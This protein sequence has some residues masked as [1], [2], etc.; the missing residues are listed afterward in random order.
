M[1]HL[2]SRRSDHQF[3][4][5]SLFGIVLGRDYF[6]VSRTQLSELIELIFYGVVNIRLHE[7]R[8]RTLTFGGR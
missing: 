3:H 5:W 4:S 7:V 8:I 6:P 1:V 2:S